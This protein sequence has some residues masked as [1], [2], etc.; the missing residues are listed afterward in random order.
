[1]IP[2]ARKSLLW[3]GVVT[4]AAALSF[5]FVAYAFTIPDNDEKEAPPTQVAAIESSAPVE[6][7]AQATPPV[8]KEEAAPAAAAATSKAP[9]PAWNVDKAASKIAFSGDGATGPFTGS[10]GSW[11]ADIHFSPENL[12]ASKA[13]VTIQMGS[14]TIPDPTGKAMLKEGDWFSV[15]KF[16]TAKFT[17]N[18]F[19]HLG[20]DKY[21]A[22]GVLEI[23]G[24][25]S[26][27]RLPFTLTIAGKTA[28]MKGTAQIDRLKWKV[29]EGTAT[30]G[31]GEDSWASG[32]IGVSVT[33]RATQ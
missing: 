3:P 16:P 18:T 14:A 25:S 6:S 8:A 19:K 9:P 4:G 11:S 12:A 22:D 1:M 29:G 31:E 2:S 17:T 23:K 13:V 28:M 24:V 10:F 30:K 20:G 27:V 33:V 15:D 32:T 26:P 21:E 5:A 7:A